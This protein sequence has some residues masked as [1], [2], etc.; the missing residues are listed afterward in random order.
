MKRAA[1]PVILLFS[2]LAA[3][4]QVTPV[5]DQY[6]LNPVLINPAFTGGRGVLN[7]AAFYRRQWTGIK[8]A[9][10]TVTLAA[11]APFIDDKVGLGISIIHDKTGV[12]RENSFSTSYAYRTE[13]WNGTIS[14]GLKAGLLTTNTRWSDLVVL[15]PGDELY[16]NDT[17]VNVVPDFSFGIYY[18]SK[19]Y[20]AGFSVPRLLGYKFN[21]EKNGYTIKFNPRQYYY[22]FNGGYL[23]EIAPEINFIPSTLISLSPGEKMLADINAVFSFSDRMWAGMSYRSTK[24]LAGIFQFGVTR[25]LRFAYTYFIDFGLLGRFN[26]GSH[27]LMLRYEFQYKANVVNP[28]IF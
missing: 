2:I 21:F 26:N 6:M 24:S 7:I 23:F 1:F 15:D 25:Q 17:K 16:L 14:F 20:F 19:K 5:T 27:E 13:A 12:T 22:L 10:E 28:L 8:G 18:T 9:P 11:D 3:E 4:G